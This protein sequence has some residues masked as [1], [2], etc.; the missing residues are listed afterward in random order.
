MR[1]MRNLLTS[2]ESE[3][4]DLQ[5]SSARSM[6]RREGAEQAIFVDAV[7]LPGAI[8]SIAE[9]GSEICKVEAPRNRRRSA[10]VVLHPCCVSGDPSLGDI[11]ELDFWQLPKRA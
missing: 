11:N 9:I 3:R 4:Y 7:E 5:L 2:M 1:K 8:A 10:V 6:Q